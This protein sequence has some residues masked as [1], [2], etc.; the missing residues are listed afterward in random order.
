MTRPGF[1]FC[2]CPDSGLIREHINQLAEQ[3]APAKGAWE[4]HVYWG[5]EDVGQAFWDHLTLQGLFQVPRLL[6]LRNAHTLATAPWKA[7]SSAL[8]KPHAASFLIICLEGAWEKKQPKIPAAI[9]KQRCLA[10]AEKQGWVWRHPGFEGAPPMMKRHIQDKGKELGLTFEQG[11]LDTLMSAMPPDALSINTELQKIALAARMPQ[12]DVSTSFQ[13]EAGSNAGRHEEG[14]VSAALI[15]D[16]LQ[17]RNFV[18]ESN[19]F[20]FISHIESG[21]TRAAWQEIHRSQK[22]IDALFFPFLT[23]FA[24][25]MRTFWQIL[26]GEPVR[27][28]PYAMREKELCARNLGYEGIAKVLASLVQAEYGL[29]SGAYTSDQALEILVTDLVHIFSK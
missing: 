25:E 21:N 3:F 22:D 26:G 5:D 24:R 2:I 17:T 4:R 29:K 8:Q 16:W 19:I 14:R 11:V 1:Y 28:S 10:F 12:T 15:H 6:I 23:L 13:T 20:S 27:L 18:P 9:V 7:L